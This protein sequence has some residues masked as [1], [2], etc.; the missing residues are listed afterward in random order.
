MIKFLFLAEFW[1]QED[2]GDFLCFN[3]SAFKLI[4]SIKSLLDFNRDA[5]LPD[6]NSERDQFEFLYKC[7]RS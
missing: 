1:E 5:G 3:F 6:S 7:S 2:F 4:D